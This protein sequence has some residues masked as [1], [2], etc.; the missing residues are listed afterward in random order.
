MQISIY[1]RSLP[2]LN[3]NL[4]RY[5]KYLSR[6]NKKLPQKKIFKGAFIG[7]Q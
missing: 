3:K 2:D 6:Y 1:D 5:E 4:T 7:T